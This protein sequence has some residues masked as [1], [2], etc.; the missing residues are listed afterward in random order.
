MFLRVC[1]I[2]HIHLGPG[3][4]GTRRTNPAVDLHDLPRIDLVLLSHYHADHF[5][6]HVHISTFLSSFF[7]Q[8]QANSQVEA[9]LRR[10]LPILTTPHAHKALTSKTPASENFTAVTPLDTWYSALISIAESSSASTGKTIKVTAMPGKHVPPG[11][12]HLLDKLNEIVKAVP[13]TNGW[14]IE[15]MNGSKVG[16]DEGVGV[17]YRI[18][19]SGDTLF[20]DDL[21]DIPK[22]YPH[23]D[24]M[25]IHLGASWC[26]VR[27]LVRGN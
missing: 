20:V 27:L 10:D 14:M 9:T 13:P 7:F 12:G 15:L 18:Y 24:L 5:D 25:L 16:K 4:T 6:Q 21:K 22:R 8:T 23:V 1:Y 19:V 11:P 26:L 17:G 3:I 2:D